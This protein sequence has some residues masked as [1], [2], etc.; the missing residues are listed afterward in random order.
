MNPPWSMILFTTLA[1]AAQGLLVALVGV[2]LAQA[3]G[4]LQV[5]DALWP[6]GA[7]LVLA[8]AGSGLVAASFHLGRPLRAWRAASMW[9]TSWLSREVILLP[10]FMAA[11][12]AWGAAHWAGAPTVALGVLATLLALALYVCTGM[13]YGAVKAIP[14]WA[15]PMT[16]LNYTVL[17]LGSGWLL[18]AALA[19]MLAP[20]LAP[21]LAAMALGAIVLGALTRGAVLWRNLGRVP[22]TT[23]QSAIGVRHPRIVQKA[24]GA[25][26]GSFN[27]REFFHGRSPGFVRGMRWGAA[28]LGFVLPAA[29]LSVLAAGGAGASA[30]ALAI[31]FVVQFLGLLAERWSFFAEGQHTQNLYYRSNS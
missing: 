11:T 15:T 27:T 6:A 30:A 10:A 18:A 23:L 24:Q 7:M 21:T 28:L 17:G 2:D 31:L 16:P 12:A 1:G 22:K 20:A 8:L 19:A 14:E 3:A 26:G 29:V 25:M 4:L 13:I 5:S 9:R